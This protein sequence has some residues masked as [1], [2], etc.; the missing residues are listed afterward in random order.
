M[1]IFEIDLFWITLSPTYYGLM[2]ALSFII[3]YIILLKYI[4]LDEK[5]LDSLFLYIVLWVVIWWRLWYVFF[6]NFDYYI[7]NY[8]DIFKVWEWWMSFHWGLIWV[9]LASFIFSKL[10]KLEFLRLT[11]YLAI[12]APIGLFF[13]RI[14]NYINKELLGYPWYEWFMAIY[15]EWVWYFPSTL[16]EA[17]FEGLFLFIILFF[18]Y[19]KHY[20]KFWA[21]FISWLFLVVYSI[22]RIFIEIFFRQP[23]SHIWYIYWF[24]TMGQILSIPMFLVGFILLYKTRKNV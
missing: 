2:Y 1:K 8:L 16:L 5:K 12:V 6:Y 24:I 9:I 13:W 18:I 3:W 4:K 23:D 15:K 20:H 22:S 7:S 10:N 14:W 17:L 19:K 11:D 21:G